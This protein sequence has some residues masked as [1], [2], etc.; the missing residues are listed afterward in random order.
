MGFRIDQRSGLR[1]GRSQ[2]SDR[3]L[4]DMAGREC[5]R[6]RGR[7]FAVAPAC[8]ARAAHGVGIA[9]LDA[10]PT[11]AVDPSKPRMLQQVLVRVARPSRR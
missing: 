1:S 5:R 4:A 8:T 7:T 9:R 3:R 10:D 2:L 11:R 6:I